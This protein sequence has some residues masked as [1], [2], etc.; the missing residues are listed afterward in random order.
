M[1]TIYRGKT[2]DDQLTFHGTWSVWRP[3]WWCGSLGHRDLDDT[4]TDNT[5]SSSS[6]S[7]SASSLSSVIIPAVVGMTS[8]NYNNF[9]QSMLQISGKITKNYCAFQ[10]T[11]DWLYS[12]HMRDDMW[13]SHW[14]TDALLYNSCTETYILHSSETWPVQ[15]ETELA[16]FTAETRINRPGLSHTRSAGQKPARCFHQAREAYEA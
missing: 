13:M 6:S 9:L 12:T 4:A 3:D 2:R 11:G 10:Y 1:Y 7:S 15:G 8:Y 14:Q 16:L 5:S